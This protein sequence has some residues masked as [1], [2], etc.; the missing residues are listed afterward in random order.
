MGRTQADRRPGPPSRL[1]A[2]G[3]RLW[4]DTTADYDFAAHELS[5]LE[6]ACATLDAIRVLERQV[7]D[8]GPMLVGSTG[9][10]VLHPAVAEAR[11]QRLALARLVAQLALPDE[12]GGAVESPQTTRAREAAQSRWRAQRRRE[13]AAGGSA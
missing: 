9:Q 2:A 13:G 8:D 3:R 5:L 10:P 11:Q 7:A 1:A 4:R 12:D 6:A